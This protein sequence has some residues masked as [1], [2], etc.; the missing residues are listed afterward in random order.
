MRP[1]GLSVAVYEPLIDGGRQ[2]FL[3]ERPGNYGHT[4]KA[5]GG[6]WSMRFTVSGKQDEVEGWIERGLGRHVEVH[7]DAL[8]IIWEIQQVY[9]NFI[10]ALDSYL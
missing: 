2:M 5:V 8:G 10:Q 7:D 1:P 3:V 9:K 4:T 6:Y